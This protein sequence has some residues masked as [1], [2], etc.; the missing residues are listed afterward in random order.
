M[1]KLFPRQRMVNTI[2]D[3]LEDYANIKTKLTMYL[4]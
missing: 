4:F 3:I 2:K 1:A